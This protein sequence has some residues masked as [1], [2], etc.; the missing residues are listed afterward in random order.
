MLNPLTLFS[1][2]GVCRTRQMFCSRTFDDSA[3]LPFS[4]CFARTKRAIYQRLHFYNLLTR[5]LFER[6]NVLRAWGPKKK[7]K[8]TNINA[9]CEMQNT[10]NFSLSNYAD[11]R[12]S[13]PFGERPVACCSSTV[14]YANSLASLIK[15]CFETCCAERGESLPR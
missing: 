6:E 9:V 7:Q 3:A 4:R 5:L 8:K 13:L 11:E 1:T 2:S 15:L 10:K 12:N 14:K